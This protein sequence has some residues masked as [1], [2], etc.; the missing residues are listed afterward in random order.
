M[1]T[2]N[3]TREK[4]ESITGE[5]TCGEGC[6][7]TIINPLG[8]AFEHFDAMGVYRDTDNGFP[9]NSTSTYAFLDGREISY[10]NAVD[11]SKQLA[12][13]PE[14]HACYTRQ[15]LEFILGRDLLQVD[16]VVVRDLS[17]H[18]LNDRLSIKELLL[19]VVTSSTFRV[20]AIN[21]EVRSA[22]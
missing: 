10:Q 16:Q 2:G 21:T 1:K 17:G 7:H 20:R 14:V 19:S 11:L 18:S 4:V 13:S 12:E 15:L 22:P 5:G 3:T 8:F 6:H 9:V